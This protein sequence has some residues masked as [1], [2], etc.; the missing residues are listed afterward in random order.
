MLH[1][2][3]SQRFFVGPKWMEMVDLG[4]RAACKTYL[5]G[6]L[7]SVGRTADPLYKAHLQRDFL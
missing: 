4:V 3:V 5:A 7:G 6:D 1:L 2:P